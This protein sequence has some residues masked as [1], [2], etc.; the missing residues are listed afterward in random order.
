[1]GEKMGQGKGKLSPRRDGRKK[2]NGR[3]GPGHLHF[4][5]SRAGYLRREIG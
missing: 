3:E 5:K 2:Q 1:M 4:E